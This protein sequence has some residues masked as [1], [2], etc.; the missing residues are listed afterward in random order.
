MQASR[1]T[2]W[3]NSLAV[4]LLV[5]LG[6]ACIAAG[7]WQLGRAAERHA[8]ATAIEAGR[9]APPIRLDARTQDGAD[10]H[11]ASTRGTWLHDFTVLLDN[12]NLK[13]VPGLWVA[14]PLRLADDP[15]H[16]VLV[17]RGWIERPLP[18]ATLPDLAPPPGPAEVRGTLLHRVPRIF[19]LG[20]LTGRE[21]DRPRF[22]AAAAEPPR[23]QNLALSDLAAATGLALLPVVIEQSPVPGSPLVQEWPGPSLD[24][25]QNTNYALQWFG[26]SAIALIAALVLAW[27]TARGA[28]RPAP[29]DSS[30]S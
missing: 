25:A 27:R 14:T 21:P 16:A 24:A 30:A 13:G 8:L 3:R 29:E 2:L 15:G 18:P 22:S 4:L 1:R 11:A 10:W 19:D 5:A 9:H 28:R 17:L 12:R 20:T 7:R 23:V 6:V 26:F